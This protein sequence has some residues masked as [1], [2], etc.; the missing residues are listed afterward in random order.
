MWLKISKKNFMTKFLSTPAFV[1]ISFWQTTEDSCDLTYFSIKL[2]EEAR[3]GLPC[4]MRLPRLQRF[5][6]LFGDS[7]G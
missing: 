3:K 6:E 4:T 7:P 1:G 2:E 5:I